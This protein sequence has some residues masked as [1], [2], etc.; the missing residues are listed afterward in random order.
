MCAV[1]VIVC[2]R[3]SLSLSPRERRQRSYTQTHTV[4][5]WVC[6]STRDTCI[7][8]RATAL[9]DGVLMVSGAVCSMVEGNELSALL[10]SLSLLLKRE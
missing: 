4:T 3:V 6:A 2:V 9:S 8:T 5:P 10:L 1:C 7:Y